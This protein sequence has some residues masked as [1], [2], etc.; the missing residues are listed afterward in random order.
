MGAT[1]GRGVGYL[2]ILLNCLGISGKS[3]FIPLLYQ[4]GLTSGEIVAGRLLFAIPA[5]WLFFLV[6]VPKREWRL[7]DGKEWGVIVV[8]SVIT[9]I[10][11][12]THTIAYAMMSPAVTSVLVYVFPLFVVM[13][14]WVIFKQRPERNV[15][16]VVPLVYLGLVLLV[17]AGQG[18]LVV[19]NWKG[20]AYTV[21]A[22][23][24][25][26]LY[27]VFQ[28][29]AYGPA[30]PL[31]LGP[32]AYCAWASFVTLAVTIPF[33]MGD[34][35]SL[36]FLGRTRVICLFA[37]FSL[38]STAVPF[39]AL[40]MAVQILGATTSAI[41]STITPGLTVVAT[42]LVL[43]DRLSHLQYSGVVLVMIG[44]IILRTPLKQSKVMAPTEVREN[45][46]EEGVLRRG[47]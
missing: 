9:A 32:V 16:V 7:P 42:A 35:Q 15:W 36:E 23:L 13:F 20:V 33:V 5:L 40:L 34:I 47:A 4:E 11:I 31:R 8:L 45:L 26:S 3:V 30:G 21:G 43:D 44:L 1:R 28:S 18:P 39:V 12:I 27:L 6:L 22:A 41:V 2:L 19:S 37:A 25:F 17:G 29:R 46:P 10:P 24:S 14:E 38:F